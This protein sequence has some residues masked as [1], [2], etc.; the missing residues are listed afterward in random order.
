MSY[1]TVPVPSVVGELFVDMSIT[2][3]LPTKLLT[4]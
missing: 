4:H 1:G 2:L 3:K